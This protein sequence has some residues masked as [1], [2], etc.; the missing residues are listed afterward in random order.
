[1]RIYG[2]ISALARGQ[3]QRLLISRILHPDFITD[4]ERLRMVYGMRNEVK[5]I[6]CFYVKRWYN[7]RVNA[8]LRKIRVNQEVRCENYR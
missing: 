5:R 8:F 2:G 3:K 6:G 1:M 7:G 4:E